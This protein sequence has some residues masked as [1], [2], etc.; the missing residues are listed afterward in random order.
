MLSAGTM[1]T[2]SSQHSAFSVHKFAKQQFDAVK[3]NLHPLH[4]L[5]IL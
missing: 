5:I 2:I 1:H 4:A 3:I